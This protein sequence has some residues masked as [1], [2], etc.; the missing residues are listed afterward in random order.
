MSFLLKIVDGGSAA[1]G[2]VPG[3]PVADVNVYAFG[4]DGQ[5]PIGQTNADGE[6]LVNLS[7]ISGLSNFRLS[8]VGLEPVTVTAPMEPHAVLPVVMYGVGALPDLDVRPE[9]RP[10]VPPTP[11]ASSKMPLVLGILA[12]AAFLAAGSQSRPRKRGR[13]DL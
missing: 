1:L 13:G 9:P 2:D 3:A 6:F 11:P 4:P 5:Y 7:Y 10:P 8:K 12:A